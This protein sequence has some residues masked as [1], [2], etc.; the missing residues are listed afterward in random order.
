MLRKERSKTGIEKA[1]EL[2][3]FKMMSDFMQKAV[4]KSSIYK[5]IK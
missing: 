1:I 5:K 2:K 3:R 4:L